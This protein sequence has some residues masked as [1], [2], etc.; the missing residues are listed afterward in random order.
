M[1]RRI[2]SV[3]G[4]PDAI[5]R[6][7]YEGEAHSRI[8]YPGISSCISITGVKPAGELV[9]AHITVATE[10]E[11][12][13]G[14]LATMKSHGGNN[15]HYFYVIGPLQREFKPKTSVKSFNTRKKIR[16]LIKST[17]NKNAIVKF[18]DTSECGDIHV[19]AEKNGINTDFYWIKS[20]GNMVMGNIYPAFTGR[21]A[22]GPNQFVVR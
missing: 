8:C 21:T 11:L 15:C 12:I 9:G 7:E 13:D 4:G 3:S 18:Y 20:Q 22:I 17:L 16:D 1:A 6:E 2:K 14:L 10:K 19:F 5:V